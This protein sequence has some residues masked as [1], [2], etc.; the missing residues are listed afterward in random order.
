MHITAVST[1][2]V[3]CGV[4]GSVSGSG[5]CAWSSYG[6]SVPDWFPLGTLVSS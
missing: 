4:A 3:G 5:L 6:L 2:A 1:V